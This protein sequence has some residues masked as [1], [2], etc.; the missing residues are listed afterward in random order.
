VQYPSSGPIVIDGKADVVLKD[1]QITSTTGDCLVIRNSQRVTITNVQIGPCGGRGIEVSRSAD[2]RI[3]NNYIHPEFRST[4]CCDRGDGVM[5]YLTNGLVVQDNVIAYGETNVELMG[6]TNAQVLRNRLVNPLGPFPRGQQVQVWAHGTTRSSDVLIQGNSTTAAADGYKLP[7]GQWDAI[8][9]G[10]SD[11]ITVRDNH[12]NGGRSQ[13][14]C[15]I[16]VDHDANNVQMLSNT[17]LHTGQCGIGVGSGTNHVV[18]NNRIFNNGLNLPNVGNTA[19]SVWKQYDGAC[20]PVQVTNN[21]AVT[22]RPNGQLSSFWNGGGCGTVTQFGNV[23]DQAAVAALTPAEAI[24]APPTTTPI[25]PLDGGASILL[26][27]GLSV[28]P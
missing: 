19:I 4:A 15:G 7:D 24:L 17:L 20:G 9:L 3:T 16:V 21:A 18:D 1:L 12:I 5:V 25:M 8:N 13:S 23:Y 14:G 6:V 10:M 2:V 11:R 27:P 22:V 26:S 28:A